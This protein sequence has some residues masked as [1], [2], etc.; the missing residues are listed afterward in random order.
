MPR[1]IVRNLS[2][3][4]NRISVQ[5]IIKGHSNLDEM[6]KKAR[7]KLENYQEFLSRKIDVNFEENL[8][9][10]EDLST[11]SFR[12]FNFQIIKEA[13][14]FNANIDKESFIKVVKCWLIEE[15]DKKSLN[16]CI[17]RFAFLV[18]TIYA[19]NGFNHVHSQKLLELIKQ[20][21]YY[22]ISP[23]KTLEISEATDTTTLQ[24][25]S[26]IISFLE[27]YNCEDYAYLIN[28]LKDLILK[29]KN[30][31][32]YRT[33]PEFKD[34]LKVK[35]FLDEWFETTLKEND[36][37][38]LLKFFPLVLWWRLTTL[39]PLRPIE[40]CKI[41][42][43]CLVE[44]NGKYFITFPRFKYHR[45][46]EHRTK[47]TYDTLP[48]PSDI[49]NLFKYYI[50]LIDSDKQLEYL[51]DY[52]VYSKYTVKKTK[53]RKRK[54]YF[55]VR[56]LHVML[57]RFY[58]DIVYSKYK[59]SILNIKDSYKHFMHKNNLLHEA[60]KDVINSMLLVG[61]LRH[62]AI[63]NMMMQGYDK[64]EIQRLAGHITESTQFSYYNHMDNW[65]DIEIHKIERQFRLLKPLDSFSYGNKLI[66]INADTREFISNQ[67]KRQYINK[68]S[69]E[70]YEDFLK[71][72]IGYCKD[73]TM[74]CPT[75]NWKH[76]GCYFCEY[77]TISPEELNEKEE[78]IIDDL[79]LINQDLRE[80]VNFIRVL[81]KKQLDELGNVNISIKMDLTSTASELQLGLKNIAR[82]K[83]MLGVGD[84]E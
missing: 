56:S 14:L 61:D 39:I 55:E 80:K 16:T 10:F 22:T 4:K 71:L 8:W 60:P 72:S 73:K 9:K 66:N 48:I 5:D 37:T 36:Q 25:I 70:S 6:L 62:I 1:N 53:Y 12:N 76:S 29:F 49:F 23:S 58:I 84:H 27:F 3:D 77:W 44:Q 54:S 11:Y 81:Q 18:S 65:M 50:S 35:I 74:P 64:V 40:F 7:H 82:L 34:V 30:T 31:N 28:S 47:I 26:V 19:T 83:Q 67:Y 32:T 59:V 24:N 57:V 38:E 41:K 20:K 21:C 79:N 13:I 68:N 43:D 69:K 45:K 2:V 78:I 52:D 51:L 42:R 15:L 63:I 75:F 46:G 17:A 33:L